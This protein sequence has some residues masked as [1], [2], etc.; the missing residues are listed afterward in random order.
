MKL[1]LSER[2]VVSFK[3]R[4]CNLDKT[5][6]ICIDLNS[7]NISFIYK[8]I[9]FEIVLELNLNVNEQISGVKRFQNYL[10]KEKII[11]LLRKLYFFL[12]SD[13]F[14]LCMSCKS[15]FNIRRV[16]YEYSVIESTSFRILVDTRSFSFHV[17]NHKSNTLTVEVRLIY[18]FT[19]SI[20]IFG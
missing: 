11:T 15:L 5:G 6:T 12:W 18:R 13:Y 4:V 9:L 19:L 10:L 8:N 14:K 3:K 2:N 7:N 1:F 20:H 16:L 17:I